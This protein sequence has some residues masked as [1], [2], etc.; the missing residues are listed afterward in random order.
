MRSHCH[1]GS[2]QRPG[3]QGAWRGPRAG[4]GPRLSEDPD[5]FLSLLSHAPTGWPQKAALGAQ[6]GGGGAQVPQAEQRAAGGKPDQPI[7]RV[8][9]GELHPR[10]G[11]HQATVDV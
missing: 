11:G 7:R 9:F 4:A 5:I 3:E 10:P 1:P 8:A 2:N 6:G